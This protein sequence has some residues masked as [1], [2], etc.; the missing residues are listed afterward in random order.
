MPHTRTRRQVLQSGLVGSAALLGL[1]KLDF[2]SRLP[3]VAAQDAADARKIVRFA[4]DVEPLVKLIEETPRDA[5]L[6]AIAA[7]LK[8]GA[9]YEQTL[10]AL[11][12]AGIRNVQPRPSVGFKFHSVLVVNSAHIASLAAP[13]AE[14][15]LPIFWALDYFKHAQAQDV[16]EGNWTMEPVKEFF[17]P[18]PHRARAALASAMERW[19]EHGA[20]AAAA[21]MARTASAGE[22]YEVFW[23]YGMRDFRSIGHKAIYVANSWRTLQSIGWR[24]GEPVVRSLAY[25]LLNHGDE[26]NPAQSDHAADRPW[27]RSVPLAAKI[28]ADWRDGKPSTAAASE[29][30]R[31]VRDASD[32]EASNL[33]ATLLNRGVAPASI[34]DGLFAGAGELLLRQA[35]II[36]LHAV[37][38]T[39]ALHYAYLASANDETRRLAM[40]QAAAFLP[41]FRDAMPARG[42]VGEARIDTLEASPTNAKGN[43]R[44]G[45]IF[46]T[47]TTDRGRAVEQA[48]GYLEDGHSARQLMSAARLL[49]FL[50]GDDAHDYKFSSAVLED[51]FHVS[52]PWR[53]R[54]LASSLALLRSSGEPENPL[55]ERAREAMRNV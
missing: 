34:W 10:A 3:V 44:I 37:T 42:P 23:R 15:W 1:S 25:A 12:L 17:L 24:H 54:L 39:N 11:F 6:E 19:D 40:L 9:S 52:P 13:P 45:E 47:A 55:A 31:S 29:L 5:L 7:R 48:L 4:G 2:L 8:A 32:E 21:A 46:A 36:S 27:R 53:E 50:K 51:F 43:G 28:R 14:R 26:D 41:L 35:G 49:V 16:R 30:L 38:T 18:R 22:T 20:D 33:V